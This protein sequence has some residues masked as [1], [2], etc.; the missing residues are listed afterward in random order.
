MAPTMVHPAETLLWDR[1]FR[2]VNHSSTPFCVRMAT[3]FSRRQAEQLVG[4]AV[5][6]PASAIRSAPLVSNPDGAVFALGCYRLCDT[7]DVEL[8]EAGR[9][10]AGRE[11]LLPQT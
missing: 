2:I 8:T 5:V 4:G 11:A 10:N 6:A 7:V 1:R 3:G 9:R